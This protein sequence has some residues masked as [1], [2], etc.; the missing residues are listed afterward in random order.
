MDPLL[1]FYLV[2]WVVT[3]VF[4][5]L[6]ILARE[7][8]PRD[9]DEWLGA[10]IVTAVIIGLMSVWPIWAALLAWAHFDGESE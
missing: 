10:L 8:L 9:S 7:G 5:W 4:L 1:I 3:S 2:G 6:D